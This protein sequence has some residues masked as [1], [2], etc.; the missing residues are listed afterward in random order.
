MG[1]NKSSKAASV[2]NR[3]LF[4]RISYLYQAANYVAANDTVST[5]QQ[6]TGTESIPPKLSEQLNEKIPSPASQQP[7]PAEASVPAC[8]APLS[9]QLIAHLRDV[10]LK[11]QVRLSQSIKRSICKGCGSLLIPG[12]TSAA[13]IENQ[14]HGG[15]KPWADV[16]VLRCEACGTEKRFPMAAKRQPH[17]AERNKGLHMDVDHHQ[18]H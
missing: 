15:K 10:S 9:R 3:L 1:K 13:T 12:S 2:P 16:L 11:G 7:L 14:S 5:S 18:Y 4:S 8:G 17:K 6:R